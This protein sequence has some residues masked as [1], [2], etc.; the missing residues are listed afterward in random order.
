[1]YANS[2][3]GFEQVDIQTAGEQN[4]SNKRIYENSFKSFRTLIH[5]IN[6]WHADKSRS[7]LFHSFSSC[8]LGSPVTEPKWEIRHS[9]CFAT[10]R[11]QAILFRARSAMKQ[12]KE[13]SNDTTRPNWHFRFCAARFLSI[14]FFFLSLSNLVLVA[15]CAFIVITAMSCLFRRGVRRKVKSVTFVLSHGSDGH[16]RAVFLF[17]TFVSFFLPFCA[18]A[19]YVIK[20]S[21]RMRER[22]YHPILSFLNTV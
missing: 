13:N 8:R 3:N 22:H 6:C 4:R 17:Y 19:L 21:R 14:F 16:A 11:F 10:D 7:T 1:M 15:R 20:G 12:R 2:A 9:K 5:T 18:T